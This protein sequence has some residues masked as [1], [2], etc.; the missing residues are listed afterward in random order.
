MKEL[1]TYLDLCTQV[2]ELSKPKVPEADYNFYKSYLQDAKG[3]IL[4]PMCGTG[5]FLLSFLEDGFKLQGFDASQNMLNSLNKKA[6]LLVLSPNAWHGYVEQIKQDDYFSLIF[7]PSRSFGLL[8]NELVANNS[9]KS[10]YNIL[11]LA[12]VLVFETETSK[13]IPE[14]FRVPRSSVYKRNDGSMILAT[15]FDVPPEKKRR[16]KY[17]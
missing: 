6:K 10:F 12:G 7:I 9:L 14:K 15:F 1:D 3:K 5:R 16:N 11:E 13:S 4:E 17:L 8:I 2:Y